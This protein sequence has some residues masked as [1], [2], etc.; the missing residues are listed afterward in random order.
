MPRDWRAGPVALPIILRPAELLE[1]VEG[2]RLQVERPLKSRSL[3]HSP[4]LAVEAMSHPLGFWDLYAPGMKCV[5]S[6]YPPYMVGDTLWVR[7]RWGW[8]RVGNNF[9]RKGTKDVVVERAVPVGRRHRLQGWGPPKTMP[10]EAAQLE[11]TVTACQAV[12]VAHRSWV[13]RTSFTV[14]QVKPAGW[15]LA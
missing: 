8:R 3:N 5:A 6:L 4:E 7:E 10:R 15:V 2:A 11:L 14:Q 12:L 9:G 13:W 1:V